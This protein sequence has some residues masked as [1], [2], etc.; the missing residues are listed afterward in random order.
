LH[1]V[2]HFIRTELKSMQFPK[3]A[4]F[5]AFPTRFQLNTDNLPKDFIDFY[6]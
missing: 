6:L 1:L 5:C 4:H 2:C 3:T